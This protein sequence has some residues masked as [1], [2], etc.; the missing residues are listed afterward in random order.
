MS[1]S[2]EIS[3]QNNVYYLDVIYEF[4]PL[5]TGFNNCS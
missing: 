3:K 1:D 2:N 4:F 5:S